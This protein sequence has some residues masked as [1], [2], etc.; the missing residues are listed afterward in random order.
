MCSSPLPADSPFPEDAVP[1]NKK[2]LGIYYW[3]DAEAF[4]D[5][6]IYAGTIG[7]E[8]EEPDLTDNIKQFLTTMYR[9]NWDKRKLAYQTMIIQQLYSLITDYGKLPSR[10]RRGWLDQYDSWTTGQLR[11]QLI[12]IAEAE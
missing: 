12:R 7:F 10:H 3:V 11:V 5:Y 1:A 6:P 2:F 4:K 9:Q 8:V